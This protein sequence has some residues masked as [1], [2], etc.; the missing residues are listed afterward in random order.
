MVTDLV[1][2]PDIV[3][4]F[5]LGS[6]ADKAM[7]IGQGYRISTPQQL[8]MEFPQSS[9]LFPIL[10]I[11]NTKRMASVN[12]NGFTKVFA[13]ATVIPNKTASDTHAEETVVM[14]RIS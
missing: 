11:V 6:C 12:I 5:D 7:A 1:N 3:T 2:C 9:P 4:A 14:N 10:H 8:R 13:F